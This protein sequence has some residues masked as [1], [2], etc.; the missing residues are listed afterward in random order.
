MT[1][2]V[3]V[4]AYCDPETTEVHI[5]KTGVGGAQ[6]T[7]LQ[8]GESAELTCFDLEMIRVREVPI[9]HQAEKAEDPTGDPVEGATADTAE[10]S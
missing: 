3:K 7:V 6:E 4:D 5:T 2:I 8:D 1:T 10:S 9:A